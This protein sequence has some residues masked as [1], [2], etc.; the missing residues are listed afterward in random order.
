MIEWVAGWLLLGVGMTAGAVRLFP[1]LG[2]LD[3]PQRYG[4][5]R[6][7]IPYPGGIVLAV[8]GVAAVLS[9]QPDWWPLAVAAAVT[10]AV[11]FIDDKKS[12]PV[13]PRAVVQF[14]VAGG[15]AVAGFGITQ[16]GDPFGGGMYALPVALG[17]ALT[18]VW[19]I[20]IQNALNW[21]DGLPGLC[22][23]VSA[24]GFAALGI[25]GLVRPE[26]AWEADID[27]FVQ[28]SLSLAAICGGGWLWFFRHKIL[29]GDTG[30][31]VLGL[32]LAVLSIVA[33]TKIATTLLVLGLPVLDLGFVAIRRI[34]RDKKSPFSG[35]LG[36]LHHVLA[37]R[38]GRERAV[39]LLITVSAALG[40]IAIFLTGWQKLIA[41]GFVVGLVA[42]GYRGSR[43]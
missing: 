36:H 25:F 40:G 9:V 18:V 35:D 43:G 30:S 1:R 11:G 26:V 42:G 8:L 13:A 12:L 23:G 28:L 7:R 39:L 27:T 5:T 29:L 2:L 14:L 41:L 34:F 31:Q 17:I 16:I 24:V 15:L 10:A 4:L 38:W 22:V 20:A 6:D 37:A 19:I 21:F 3:F 32:L 33:G